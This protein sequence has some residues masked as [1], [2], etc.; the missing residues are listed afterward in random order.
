[1]ETNE[2]LVGATIA[3][4]L[5][6]MTLAGGV[7]E[8]PGVPYISYAAC[9]PS[10]ELMSRIDDARYVEHVKELLHR[11][12]DLTL[13]TEIEVSIVLLSNLVEASARTPLIHEATALYGSVFCEL[14][15]SKAD[16]VWGSGAVDL[17]AY[18]KA[19][20]QQ[21]QTLRDESEATIR[22]KFFFVFR[23]DG[24]VRS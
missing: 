17:E 8:A 1:M 5:Q 10:S 14:F 13:P 15:P 7:I 23:A 21:I 24:K 22:S 4:Q 6:M 3:R 11:D 19:M 9:A 20:G 2:M 12:G 16:S 18:M